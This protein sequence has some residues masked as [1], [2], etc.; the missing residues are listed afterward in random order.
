MKKGTELKVNFTLSSVKP[1]TKSNLNPM[2]MAFFKTCKKDG[3]HKK[4]N[5]QPKAEIGKKTQ[6]MRTDLLSPSDKKLEEPA[7]T[8][9]RELSDLKHKP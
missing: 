9:L 7:V 8:S 3:T 1:F 6:G 5:Q 2:V 4:I